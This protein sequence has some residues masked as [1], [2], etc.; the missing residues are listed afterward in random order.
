MCLSV[1]SSFF[2]LPYLKGISMEIQ[3]YLNTRVLTCL[4]ICINML[5]RDIIF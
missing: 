2:S 5:I 1:N 3:L 4:H